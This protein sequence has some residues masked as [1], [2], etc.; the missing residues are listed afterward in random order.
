MS[1]FLTLAIYF[2][3]EK[4]INFVIPENKISLMILLTSVSFAISLALFTMVAYL[5]EPNCSIESKSLNKSKHKSCK[6]NKFSSKLVTLVHK[7][8]FIYII[9][10]F[11]KEHY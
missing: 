6:M 7:T 9:Q 2:V 11:Q 3:E 8:V 1:Y 10:V 4:E 5:V